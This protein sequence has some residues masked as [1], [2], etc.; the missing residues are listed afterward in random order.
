VTNGYCTHLIEASRDRHQSVLAGRLGRV[1]RKLVLF[2]MYSASPMGSPARTVIAKIVTWTGLAL[3]AL[4]AIALYWLIWTDQSV[5]LAHTPRGPRGWISF[6]LFFP[7]AVGGG[8]A[9]LFAWVA[10][11]IDPERWSS[12]KDSGA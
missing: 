7:L 4:I 11:M 9:W 3:G 8:L 1:L 12:D 10:G 6:H 5:D 2:A